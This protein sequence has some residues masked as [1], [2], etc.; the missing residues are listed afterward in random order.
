MDAWTLTLRSHLRA[1]LAAGVWIAALWAF[2]W[3]L[4]PAGL[5]GSEVWAWIGAF[6]LAFGS[7]WLGWAI[8]QAWIH[9]RRYRKAEALWASGGYASDVV[10]LLAGVTLATGELGHRVWLLRARANL[11]L[12]YR[13]LAWAESEEAHLARVPWWFRGLLRCYLRA[14]PDRSPAY[15]ERTGPVWMRLVPGM[16]SLVWRLAIQRLRQEG[17]EARASAWELILSVLPHATEDPVLLE[18]LMLALLGRLQER[19]ASER[20][21]GSQPGEPE[22]QAA[23]ERVL[24]LL[25]HRHGAPRVG[26]D[27]VPPA[28]HLVRRGRYGEALALAGTLPPDR[29]PEALWVAAVA[30]RKALGDLDGAWKTT[31]QALDR[32][33]ASFR[34][35]MMR[36][37]LALDLRRHAEALDALSRAQALIEDGG[38]LEAVRE[39]HT[40]RAEYAYWIAKDPDEAARHLDFLPAEEDAEGRPPLRLLILLDQER[41]DD[42]LG[43][44]APMLA[45]QPEHP[46][47][48]LVQAEGLAGLEAWESL[49]AHLDGV[50]EAARQRPVFWHLR[51]I[52]R[53]HLG[54]LQGSREDLE[55]SAHLEPE[56]LRFMLDAGHACADLGEWERAE[57]FWRQALRLDEQ[58]EEALTQ[59]SE[60]RRTLHDEEGAKRL[61]RECLLH[62]PE[63]ETAQVMLAELEAN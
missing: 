13:N 52:C 31:D 36:E 38:P 35:W 61:L 27:R 23:F 58:S 11:S 22:L 16:P 55:R 12:G 42:A 25:L 49:R 53:A 46:D 3:T 54:D 41:Y 24:D 17:P 29:T 2:H 57:H 51:G 9:P 4:G 26:W 45:R 60:A 56:N 21:L 14:V 62:H 59:L 18:D 30:A 37:D 39:W 43:E 28:L 19:P 20:S 15:L 44:V 8:R 6:L 10:D 40:R 48:Q 63:S 33:P 1:A 7:S 50:G 47:L 34:L 32:E 5:G